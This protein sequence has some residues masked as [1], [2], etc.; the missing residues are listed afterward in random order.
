MPDV[1]DWNDEIHGTNAGFKK[2]AQRFRTV[3]NSAI[4]TTS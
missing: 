2:V 1:S 3:M 4:N